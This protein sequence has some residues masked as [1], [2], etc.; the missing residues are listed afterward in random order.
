MNPYLHP[1][2]EA[3]IRELLARG[4]DIETVA[5]RFGMTPNGLRMT[6]LYHERHGTKPAPRKRRKL[7]GERIKE[8]AERRRKTTPA[9]D[10]P[11]AGN[12]GDDQG[13]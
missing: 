3:R 1:C 4:E 6:L 9:R 7:V 5:E 10:K 13:R 2:K 8:R 12:S 11:R